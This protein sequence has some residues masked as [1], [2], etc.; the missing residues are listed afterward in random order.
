M[1]VLFPP[2]PQDENFD[3]SLSAPQS[4]DSPISITDE[5]HPHGT[6]GGGG[7][8]GT[9]GVVDGGGGEGEKRPG[10]DEL[11]SK[12]AVKIDGSL[13]QI[14]EDSEEEEEGPSVSNRGLIHLL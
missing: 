10:I 14:F 1:G 9:F 12:E 3:P 7:A 2:G 13:D 5:G 4:V 11:L 6:A 8:G